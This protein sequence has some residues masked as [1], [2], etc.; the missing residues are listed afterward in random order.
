[1]STT[2]KLSKAGKSDAECLHVKA[3]G[4]LGR[5]HPKGCD[6]DAANA[7]LSAVAYNFRR[8]LE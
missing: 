5:C 3:E 2:P 8:I 6:G 7:I 4:H 1:M